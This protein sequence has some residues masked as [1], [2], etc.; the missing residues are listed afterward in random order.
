MCDKKGK[1]KERRKG[2][3]SVQYDKPQDGF[4]WDANIL[5][6]ICMLQVTCV[7]R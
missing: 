3:D 4:K 7:T 2:T 5:F 1:N 6:L